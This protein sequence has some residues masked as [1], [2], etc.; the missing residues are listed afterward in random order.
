MHLV[1][2]ELHQSVPADLQRLVSL[3]SWLPSC[4]LVSLQSAMLFLALGCLRRLQVCWTA[5][6]TGTPPIYSS[7]PLDCGLPS[8]LIA[9]HMPL[10][11]LVVQVAVGTADGCAILVDLHQGR[12][13]QRLG[14]QSGPVQGLAWVSLLLLCQ[15]QLHS[16][17]SHSPQGR[18]WPMLQHTDWMQ[19]AAPY[20]A[21]HE[22]AIS[23]DTMT[24]SPILLLTMPTDLSWM[25]CVLQ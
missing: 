5:K 20:H 16:V 11:P 19:G 22:L 3:A 9:A 24:R 6:Q 8:I 23:T 15:Q 12:E 4:Y 17:S 14:Q 21:A 13:L 10:L 2:Q 18:Q 1:S 7:G 25:Q